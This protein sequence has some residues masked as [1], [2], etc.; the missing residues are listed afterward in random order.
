MR[1]NFEIPHVANVAADE[2][3]RQGRSVVR[4]NF[5]RRGFPESGRNYLRAEER[6]LAVGP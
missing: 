2:D 1:G 5:G 6:S 3:E 4:G